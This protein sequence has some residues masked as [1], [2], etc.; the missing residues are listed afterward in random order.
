[1]GKLSVIV[2]GGFWLAYHDVLPEFE[3]R[4]GIAVHTLSGASQGTGPKTI[5]W[6]LENG[7]EIDAVILSEEG[8]AELVEIGQ[9][10]D[11]SAV[12]L[13][14]V[15]LAAAVRQGS[16]KPDIGNV[17]TFTRTL[18]KA[19][20]VVMPGST[21]GL[22]VKNEIFP[23]LRIADRVSARV[24]TRGT[25]ST[26]ALAA[27]EA[28]LAIGPVSELVDQPG[29]EL[30][31]SLPDEVQ[32]VQIFTSAIVASSKN[33]AQAKQLI[34]FLASDDT[35]TAIERSGM[36]P[37]GERSMRSRKSISARRSL[38]QVH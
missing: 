29:I 30:V 3:R 21:S 14:S 37:W 28:D 38:T 2:S 7:A 24:M 13:A 9:I 15:P 17:E 32:L 12:P 11:G 5:K 27:G 6:Q 1:M 22:F 10:L 16:P 25:D 34:D 33:I 20:S 19:R 31:G 8:L 35:L 23:R 18:L 26:A 36:E 4:T